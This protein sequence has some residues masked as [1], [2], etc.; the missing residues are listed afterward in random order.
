MSAF[1]P[2][3]GLNRH[4]SRATIH[5]TS[6]YGGLR[7]PEVYTEQGIGQIRL[8]I[9]HLRRGD[10]T[11]KLLVVAMS[12]MQ[13]RVG[14]R[15]LFLNLPYPKY[16]G[17]IKYTWL[18]S[19]W[20]FLQVT[21]VKIMIPGVPLLSAQREQDFFL[22]S[23]FV[24]KGFTKGDL[25]LI[26]QCRLYHQVITLA[27]ITGTDRTKIDEVY[28]SSRRHPYRVSSL[29]WPAQHCPSPK[30]WRKWNAALQS[31]L[32][33]RKLPVPLGKWI[34]R[35]HQQWSWWVRLLDMVLFYEQPQGWERYLP[36]RYKATKQTRAANKP[37]YFANHG[38]NSDPP[39]GAMA[40]A[41]LLSE[42][43]DGDLFTITWSE[44]LPPPKS[45]RQ[46]QDSPPPEIVEDDH[47]SESESP[48]YRNY[49]RGFMQV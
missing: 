12:I 15:I 34:T 49:C 44:E 18:S 26:N 46:T 9:G 29:K 11:G 17:W 8:L 2:K 13:L 32:Y 7:I 37:W 43:M 6:A 23:E 25:E 41:T 36:N 30:V 35:P 45:P 14:S 33:K 1:L 19:L 42:S 27:D 3:I 16:A 31:L 20:Q 38:P 5:G 4:T 10:Q 39:E 21:N 47:W 48:R 40:V 22:M 24:Y 28:T